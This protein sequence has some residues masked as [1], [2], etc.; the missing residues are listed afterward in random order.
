MDITLYYSYKSLL[1][2]VHLCL[3][4]ARMERAGAYTVNYI[5]TLCS[6]EILLFL[7]TFLNLALIYGDIKKNKKI[8]EEEE[9][10]NRGFADFHVYL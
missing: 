4:H 1:A 6:L 2:A 3:A 9:E 5:F 8:Q 7:V 10:E